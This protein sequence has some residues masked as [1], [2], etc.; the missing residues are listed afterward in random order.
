MGRA[1]K[2]SA[3]NFERVTVEGKTNTIFFQL[4]GHFACNK[5]MQFNIE[6]ILRKAKQ[7]DMGRKEKM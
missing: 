1:Q 5:R 6:D 4:D 2:A 3:R 7:A